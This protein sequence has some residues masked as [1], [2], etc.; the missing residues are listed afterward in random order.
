MPPVLRRHSKHTQTKHVSESSESCLNQCS[1]H[2]QRKKALFGGTH[3]F[4]E[5]FEN[6]FVKSMRQRLSPL[7]VKMSY[8]IPDR[9]CPRRPLKK[10]GDEQKAYEWV[11]QVDGVPCKL[12]EETSTH[13][14]L[15]S[16]A[17]DVDS[18]VRVPRDEFTA[19]FVKA[20]MEGEVILGVKYPGGRL[21]VSEF[22][23]RKEA[24]ALVA[25]AVKVVCDESLQKKL[26]QVALSQ[27]STHTVGV[28]EY[29]AY[30]AGTRVTKS[31][32]S[33]GDPIFNRAKRWLPPV[34]MEYDTFK[35]SKGFPAPLGIRPKDFCL[36]SQVIHGVTELL[37]QMARF[38]SSPPALV[39][40]VSNLP[41][42]VIPAGV[43]CCKW[44]GGPVDAKKCTAAYKSATNYIEI[45]HRD[46]NGMFSPENMY[47]GHGD[48]N[49]RQGGYTEL[50]RIQDAA[51][52]ALMHPEYK[53]ELLRQ[54]GL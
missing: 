43:H 33:L 19:Q 49:R 38:E 20:E 22:D 42:V 23:K 6:G 5:T 50:D 46:P 29:F 15:H 25:E 1:N 9:T 54:L 26:E 51:R 24:I 8:Y 40:F 36:P 44:C 14:I 35:E 18:R 12:L 47:W 37:V 3:Y 30:K 16:F 17:A 45:C 53:A 13:A 41:G 39:A 34:D 32:E 11:S 2:K 48:C 28:E 31:T 4:P 52:L 7:R 10:N 27:G 21:H